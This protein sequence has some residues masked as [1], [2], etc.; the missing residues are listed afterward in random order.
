[1]ICDLQFDQPIG[2]WKTAWHQALRLAKVKARWHDLR[3]TLISRLA[4][5]PNVSEETI[6]AIAGHVSAAML[7]RYS[8][9]RADAKR[10]AIQSLE[11]LNSET[12]RVQNWAQSEADELAL[13]QAESIKVLN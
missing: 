4:E 6:R 9:I 11:E 12:D 10:L 8:H 5:N 3:H 7:R 13:L 1:R 2:K